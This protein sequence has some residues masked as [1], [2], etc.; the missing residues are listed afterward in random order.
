MSISDRPSDEKMGRSSLKNS[1]SY[2]QS[3]DKTIKSV[4]FADSVGQKLVDVRN[5]VPS[6]ENLLLH[7]SNESFGSLTF[8]PN[9][10]YFRDYSNDYKWI[11]YFKD[12]DP[13]VAIYYK[14]LEQKKLV[15]ERLTIIES[16]MSSPQ[17]LYAL[18]RVANVAFTKYVFIRG[19]Y[20]NWTT[21]FEIPCKF[22]AHCEM[23]NT[24]LF[25]GNF[26]LKHGSNTISRVMEFAV[27]YT[28]N[29]ETYWDN[30]KGCNYRIYQI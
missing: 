22:E 1:S 17:E 27:G 6:S 28:V 12:L 8:S 23:T 3:E 10:L 30:N 5:F 15:L 4:S 16:E 13:S 7:S 29:G 25:I 18:I 24:D 9:P 11:S 21:Y 19:S 2:Q 14:E 26:P 20:Q